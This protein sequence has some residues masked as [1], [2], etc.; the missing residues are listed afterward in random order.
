MLWDAAYAELAFYDTLWPD[1]DGKLF[2]EACEEYGQRTRQ[3]GGV[4]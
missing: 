1:W 2:K 3:W 4:K